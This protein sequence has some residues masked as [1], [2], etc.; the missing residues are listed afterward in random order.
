M[1][2]GYKHSVHVAD[3][4]VEFIL[5]EKIHLSNTCLEPEANLSMVIIDTLPE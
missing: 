2:E 5:R 4:A 1:P 3:Y